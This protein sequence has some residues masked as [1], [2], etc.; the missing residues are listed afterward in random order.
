MCIRCWLYCRVDFAGGVHAVKATARPAV[1][2]TTAGA[3]NW[4]VSLIEDV[5]ALIA[6]ILSILVPILIVLIIGFMLL[7]FVWWRNGASDRP[8][9]NLINYPRR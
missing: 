2:T 9:L 7:A 5:L 8:R 4:L 1:T 3:G 6:A